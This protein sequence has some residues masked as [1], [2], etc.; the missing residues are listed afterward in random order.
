MPLVFFLLP[1]PPL[2]VVTLVLWLLDCVLLVPVVSV[3][4][5]PVCVPV[6]WLPMLPETAVR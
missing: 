2:V 6:V 3:W 4:L 1:L 5:V